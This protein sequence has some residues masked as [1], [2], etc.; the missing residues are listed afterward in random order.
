MVSTYNSVLQ[1]LNCL[2]ILLNDAPAYY[3]A[4]ILHPHYKHHLKAL[5]KVP[6]DYNAQR[7]GP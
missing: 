7:Y 6:N 1:S 5:W 2:L 3:A 4:T